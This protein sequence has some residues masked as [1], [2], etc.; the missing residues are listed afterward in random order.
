MEGAGADVA[1]IFAITKVAALAYLMFNLFTPPCFAAIGAMNSEIKNRKWFWGGIGLQFAVGFTVS[2]L[3]FFFGTLITKGSFGATWMP[4]LGW[5]IIAI[6][7]LIITVLII[8]KNK[9]VKKELVL[10]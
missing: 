1:A 8:K 6:I 2:F 9:E 10:G 7:V 5:S 4:I 3:V